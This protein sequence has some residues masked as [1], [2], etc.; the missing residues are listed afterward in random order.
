MTTVP[1]CLGKGWQGFLRL[2]SVWQGFCF[3][4]PFS[5]LKMKKNW[6]LCFCD[7]KENSKIQNRKYQLQF[8]LTCRKENVVFDFTK[9]TTRKL[10]F[11]QKPRGTMKKLMLLY[12]V[13]CYT[14][15]KWMQLKKFQFCTTGKAF[16]NYK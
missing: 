3:F 13:W 15:L 9:W 14:R 10:Q 16:C 5:G 4:S 11:L 12:T 1:S 2:F 6:R 8:Y 7:W